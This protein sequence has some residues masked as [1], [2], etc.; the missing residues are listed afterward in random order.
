[1]AKIISLFNFKNGVGKT[2][3][4]YAL[5]KHLECDFIEAEN[6]FLN[7]IDKNEKQAYSEEIYNYFSDINKN[8]EL[9]E[10]DIFKN[11]YVGNEDI[12]IH[13]INTNNLD[14]IKKLLALSNVI[15]V[16][17]FIDFKDL[18]KTIKS[19]KLINKIE[20][21]QKCEKKV[22]V[23]FNRLNLDKKKET[24]FTKNSEELLKQY[25]KNITFTY[26]RESKFWYRGFFTGECYL[27]FFKKTFFIIN[28]IRIL[29][30][31]H[32]STIAKF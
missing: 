5:A 9:A 1:M 4:G 22:V 12:Q 11:I 25:K 2:T 29:I 30:F 18:S 8:K 28:K 14:T 27:D 20:E 6:E 23:I 26:I 31:L 7:E 21:E 32:I 19:L 3:I 10:N 16:P 15:I 24:S 13:D 17:T